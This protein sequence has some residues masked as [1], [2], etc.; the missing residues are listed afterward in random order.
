MVQSPESERD[1]TPGSPGNRQDRHKLGVVPWAKGG[2]PSKGNG[3][4]TT[5]D[6]PYRSLATAITIL[7]R[8]GLRRTAPMGRSSTTLQDAQ[9]VDSTADRGS[10]R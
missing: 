1:Q 3:D 4:E 6:S 2:P 10:R 5:L 7:G 8:D 9:T